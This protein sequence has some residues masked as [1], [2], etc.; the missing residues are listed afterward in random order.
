MNFTGWLPFIACA[1]LSMAVSCLVFLI[2]KKMEDKGRRLHSQVAEYE[3]ELA[4]KQDVFK[5]EISETEITVSQKNG[6]V[7]SLIQML[8]SQITELN[9]YSDDF[10]KL[11]KAMSSYRNALEGLARLTLDADSRM[12]QLASDVE[13]L[14]AVKRDIADFRDDMAKSDAKLRE[15]LEQAASRFREEADQTCARLQEET[16]RL[17]TFERNVTERI[18][19]AVRDADA[20][21]DTFMQTVNNGNR[22]ALTDFNEKISAESESLF[23][24][25]EG[26]LAKL[27]NVFST[28][29]EVTDMFKDNAINVLSQIC[30]RSA[31]Q[32]VIAEELR[33][34]N[35]QKDKLVSQVAELEEQIK[36]KVAFSKQVEELSAQES[37][38]IEEMKLETDR[39]EKERELVR[40]ALEQ[41]KNYIPADSSEHQAFEIKDIDY[42]VVADEPEQSSEIPEVSEISEAAEDSVENE[43]FYPDADSEEV[44]ETGE[45]EET[46][47]YEEHVSDGEDNSHQKVEYYGEE[48]EIVFDD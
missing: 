26:F 46:G 40:Q 5:R 29:R 48:E 7:K 34:L 6:E 32:V 24:K 37:R 15:D 31:D 27:E 33:S 25:V 13:R 17:G 28:S 10:G 19:D 44:E 45:D 8:T 2:A 36:E 1:A 20:C 21:A 4:R 43:D 30:D 3:N 12:E 14:E 16:E 41:E 9:S 47:K 18:S 38:K 39:L 11:S 22:E 42:S 35:S 23:M